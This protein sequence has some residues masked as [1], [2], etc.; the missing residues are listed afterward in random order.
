VTQLVINSGARSTMRSSAS[1]GS[2]SSEAP[3]SSQQSDRMGN[4]SL[5]SRSDVKSGF[6]ASGQLDGL[7]KAFGPI[8]DGFEI[9]GPAKKRSELGAETRVVFG[10]TAT[11]GLY[12]VRLARSAR[13]ARRIVSVREA[14]A[15]FRGTHRTV[16]SHS[17]GDGGFRA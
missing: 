17:S 1:G 15:F 3:L 12:A 16:A 14:S 2:P 6:H 7:Q 11:F 9:V 4:R 10:E 5:P 8:T 13:P